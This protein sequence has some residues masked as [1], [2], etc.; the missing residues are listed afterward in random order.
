ME[1]HAQ[2][3]GGVLPIDALGE[4]HWPAR[5]IEDKSQRGPVQ[6]QSRHLPHALRPLR[7]EI[8]VAEMPVDRPDGAGARD[9]M[10]GLEKFLG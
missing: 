9:R 10:S 3:Y 5:T 1:S 2:K 4:R 6:G 8:A 7:C